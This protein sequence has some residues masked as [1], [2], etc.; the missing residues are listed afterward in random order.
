MVAR[1]TACC[2]AL[3]AC[4]LVAPS[5]GEAAAATTSRLPLGQS[6]TA[7]EVSSTGQA[8]ATMRRTDARGAWAVVDGPD[9]RRGVR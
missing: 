3:W 7:L 8:W 6:F 2:A 4:S 1:S 9:A 5:V